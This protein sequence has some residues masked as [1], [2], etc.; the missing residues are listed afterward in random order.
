MR[1]ILGAFRGS[2]PPDLNGVLTR[3]EEQ[4][5]GLDFQHLGE[6]GDGE[7]H[8]F[9]PRFD[10][11]EPLDGATQLIRLLLLGPTRFTAKFG[12]SARRRSCHEHSK[13]LLTR[14]TRALYH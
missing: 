1:V 3:F 6:L 8:V 7:S 2:P 12:Y 14:D 10:A 9:A 11:A 13:E 5:V 4:L